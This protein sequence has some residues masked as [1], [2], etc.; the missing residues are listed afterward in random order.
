MEENQGKRK[1]DEEN[2]SDSSG[3][4][5]FDDETSGSSSS[6]YDDQ[7]SSD[8]DPQ[9]KADRDDATESEEEEVSNEEM[10][11]EESE[12]E[13]A[14]QAEIQERRLLAATEKRKQFGTSGTL[15]A[16]KELFKERFEKDLASRGRTYLLSGGSL[17]ELLDQLKLVDFK[18]KSHAL[19]IFEAIQ[20]TIIR[21]MREKI[22]DPLDLIEACKSFV[23]NHIVDV[24]SLLAL[25]CPIHYRMTSIKLLA[26]LAAVD[27]IIAL[28]LLSSVDFTRDQLKMLVHHDDPTNP[29]SLRVNFIHFLMSLIIGHSPN[30][31]RKLCN[32]KSWLPSIFMGMRFDLLSSVSLVLKTLDD[33]LVMN[34]SVP[35]TSKLFAFNSKALLNLED[36]YEWNPAAF[37]EITRN[38]KV[39]IEPPDPVEVASVRELVHSLLTHLLTSTKHGIIFNDPSFGTSQ[40]NA[41]ET[42]NQFM[43][44]TGH[45][46]EDPLKQKLFSSMLSACPDLL[47]SFYSLVSQMMPIRNQARMCVVWTFLIETIDHVQFNAESF[48]S[49]DRA[50][51]VSHR[52]LLPA[53]IWEN[54]ATSISNNVGQACLLGLRFYLVVLGKIKAISATLEIRH[55]NSSKSYLNKMS[56]HLGMG[57]V[58][59]THLLEALSNFDVQESH[60][61]IMALC[62]VII[63]LNEL[64]PSALDGVKFSS[65]NIKRL[66]DVIERTK[67]TDGL[68]LLKLFKVQLL[69][70]H[71]IVKKESVF[72]L[73]KVCHTIVSSED[74]A[75]I[76]FGL[77]IIRDYMFTSGFFSNDSSELDLWM[78]CIKNH[79]Q[80]NF[81]DKLSAAVL[82]AEANKFQISNDILRTCSRHSATSRKHFDLKLDDFLKMEEKDFDEADSPCDLPDLKLSPL[83]SG[84]ICANARMGNVVKSFIIHYAHMVQLE[85]F[86]RLLKEL[87]PNGHAVLDYLDS[88]CAGKVEK[89]NFSPFTNTIFEDV[90]QCWSTGSTDFLSEVKLSDLDLV[91][92]LVIQVA[93][94]S[95]NS[96]ETVRWCEKLFG[97][98]ETK[99][100]T[101][102]TANQFRAVSLFR[103]PGLLENF[104]PVHST[105]PHINR[106]VEF[107]CRMAADASHP[108]VKPFTYRLYT[109]LDCAI[110]TKFSFEQETFEEL[111]LESSLQN[112]PMSR[113]QSLHLI[114]EILHLPSKYFVNKRKVTPWLKVLETLL[115]SACSKKLILSEDGLSKIM[116]ILSKSVVRN[117]GTS[118]D[119]PNIVYN[120]FQ[121]VGANFCGDLLPHATELLTTLC[122]ADEWYETLACYLI[123]QVD[124]VQFQLPL[125]IPLE[126]KVLLIAKGPRPIIASLDG[127]EKRIG[128]ALCSNADYLIHLNQISSLVL[129]DRICSTLVG[130]V[131]N[132]D[133][134]PSPIVLEIVQFAYTRADRLDD[135]LSLLNGWMETFLVQ[136][137]DLCVNIAES[138]DSA[139]RN[140]AHGELPSLD[141]AVVNH[142]I[143][144]GLSRPCRPMISLLQRYLSADRL[145]LDPPALFRKLTSHEQFDSVLMGSEE[146]GKCA[147]IELLST[148]TE[149]DRSLIDG[150][151]LP[152]FLAA[153]Q[154]TLS[155]ADQL[156]LKI[157]HLYEKSG[158][159]LTAYKPLLWGSAALSHYSV[160]KKPSLSRSH[161]YQTLDSLD[162]SL[163]FNTIANYPVNRDTEGI[164]DDEG[165]IYDPAFLLPVLCQLAQQEHKIKSRMFF[166]S[167][168]VGLALASLASTSLNIRRLAT[169]FLQRVHKH[170]MGQDK[171]VWSN[172]IDAVRRGIA[173]LE[174]RE[175]AK[176]KNKS[177][178]TEEDVPR[179]CSI[180]STFLARASTVLGDPTAPLYRPLHHF[181]LA[182][183]AL[184][185]FGV[186]AFLE[187]LHSTDVKYHERHREWILEVIRDGI[188]E[189]RDLQLVM[190]SFTLKIILVFYSSVLATPR[191]KRLIEQIIG[192]ALSGPDKESGLL[193][194]KYSIL[195]WAMA[196][197]KPQSVI[198][199]LPKLSPTAQYRPLVD[200]A[201]S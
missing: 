29:A 53:F 140:I 186:P 87:M 185:L 5:E 65:A 73:N 48:P 55:K 72:D 138:F 180:T 46:W 133:V 124:P 193:L 41:N 195:P 169:L 80:S 96:P 161:P 89:I 179:I 127:E 199:S 172:F 15:S 51:V 69:L 22:M 35:K 142:L 82:Y 85:G 149:K 173:E 77:G 88:L 33:N 99:S 162:P 128:K 132:G 57:P 37:V 197:H 56:A 25:S 188:R 104:S 18:K 7:A 159:K 119:L 10:E 98:I 167:G 86:T 151:R 130:I 39:V 136:D 9:S 91:A 168:A 198:A 106:I 54:L 81:G 36:L 101:K 187:L 90:I 11:N 109:E 171:I 160:N 143:S 191:T 97:E 45:P 192:K 178:N 4:E 131:G 189:P 64:I 93:I 8:D 103:C 17:D 146:S 107:L 201:A 78:K 52:L 62:D 163:V 83:L 14:K 100:K 58:T 110:R 184:K 141:Q 144:Y 145:S 3:E 105:S 196:A 24:L 154:G 153:Y 200:L 170:H 13:G 148:L 164:V 67:S 190:N 74:D 157:L 6:A 150:K 26:A 59:G 19:I 111:A 71:Q 181:I 158:V 68:M 122:F 134:Y 50:V 21:V 123:N 94:R 61:E 125:E 79:L 108:N 60:E 20:I 165:S 23:T 75:V 155:Q 70:D 49:V 34:Q 139:L 126:R 95:P 175:S 27:D 30:V 177:K 112:F 135:L 129:D 182:R 152:G 40:L 2:L 12:D 156:L 102:D 28:Q 42:A 116:R 147:L 113:S 166:Q 66:T 63:V 32:K 117:D 174:E 115:A 118:S 16:I 194:N 43:K 92:G 31:I 44:E 76:D 120:Y 137:P 47:K 121:K 183:P 84:F 38:C 114:K 1:T 176:K